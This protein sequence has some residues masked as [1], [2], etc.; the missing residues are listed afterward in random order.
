[1]WGQVQ[2]LPCLI[3]IPF[4]NS[5]KTWNQPYLGSRKDKHQMG[6][7]KIK[8]RTIYKNPDSLYYIS[9]GSKHQ[10]SIPLP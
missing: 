3:Y 7:S 9:C 2:M 4:L 1:M 5:L 10:L 6:R 8:T